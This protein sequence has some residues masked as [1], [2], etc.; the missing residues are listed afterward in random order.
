[1]SATQLD[2]AAVSPAVPARTAGGRRRLPR[3][4]LGW[5]LLGIAVVLVA[6][7][8][9]ALVVDSR[10]ILPSPIEVARDFGFSFFD[11]AGLR[12]LGVKTPGYLPNLAYTIGASALAWAIG[13]VL[14]AVVGLLSAR[15]QLFR[16]VSEPLFFVFGAVPALVLAPFFSVWF[17]QGLENKLVLVA[18]Y[19]FVSVG[20]VAQS[21][22]QAFP[23]SSEEY[24]ATQGL[25]ARARF[26]HVLV[27]GTLPVVL[28]GLR[29]ALATAIAVQTT[30][31]LLGSQFG[32]GRL[33]A[34]RA[35][36]GD[37]SSIIGLSLAL[38]AIAV[39]LDALLRAIIRGIVRWQ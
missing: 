16:S 3:V 24:A 12:Y 18:F 39:A 15:I 29:I 35:S 31:E 14:G 27:P 5:R 7:Q 1:M 37:L 13:S 19:C 36:Q 32:A 20:L 17:G 8:L 33:I 6:W 38:G 11:D 10:G 26:L 22:A 30:I 21:A 9:A 25:D 34:L 2:T 4:G 28:A 23:P